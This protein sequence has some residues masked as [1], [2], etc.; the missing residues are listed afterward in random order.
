MVGSF[1]LYRKKILKKTKKNNRYSALVKSCLSNKNHFTIAEIN[2]EAKITSS[3][4]YKFQRKSDHKSLRNHNAKRILIPYLTGAL[5]AYK[6]GLK[7]DKNRDRRNYYKRTSYR[8]FIIDPMKRTD[9]VCYEKYKKI[10]LKRSHNRRL[11]RL[12]ILW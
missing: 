10:E 12:Q 1:Y 7:R 8:W 4:E 6:L 9:E 2:R 3:R 5:D 11:A